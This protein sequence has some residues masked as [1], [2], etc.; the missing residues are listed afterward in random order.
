MALLIFIALAQLVVTVLLL[1]VVLQQVTRQEIERATGGQTITGLKQQTIRE[2][3]DAAAD[4]ATP[5]RGRP[6][7]SDRS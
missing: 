2:L 4:S 5:G 1:G 7:R 3:F 6:G